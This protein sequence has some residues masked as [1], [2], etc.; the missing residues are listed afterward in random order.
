MERQ[1]V[2]TFTF[3]KQKK[4]FNIAFQPIAGICVNGSMQRGWVLQVAFALVI[5]FPPNHSLHT[6]T[7]LSPLRSYVAP[8]R[9]RHTYTHPRLSS[10]ASHRSFLRRAAGATTFKPSRI[11]EVRCSL[12]SSS[13]KSAN[14]PQQI[15]KHYKKRS[16][17]RR[18]CCFVFLRRHRFKVSPLLLLI[19][20]AS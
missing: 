4:P 2:T 17:F 9:A 10:S 5:L 19:V 14:H 6:A 7:R 15:F 13:F 1:E 3:V 18:L 8:P 11:F 20:S 16:I 12:S